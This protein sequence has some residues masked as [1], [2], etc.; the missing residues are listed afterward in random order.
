MSKH[1][2][3]KTGN[4]SP[5]IL[6]DTFSELL[7]ESYKKF[8]ISG[9]RLDKMILK[10]RYLCEGLPFLSG[11]LSDMLSVHN[12]ALDSGVFIIPDRAGYRSQRD[13]AMPRLFN[14]WWRRLYD[15]EGRILDYS[16]DGTFLLM[17]RALRQILAFLSK[18][19]TDISD[20]KIL[21]QEEDF[22][23]IDQSIKR[24]DYRPPKGSA[25]ESLMRN[26]SVVAKDV[27]STFVLDPVEGVHGPGAVFEGF[28]P[29]DKDIFYWR[30]IPMDLVDFWRSND[31]FD[32]PFVLAGTSPLLRVVSDVLLPI[33]FMTD[34]E[35][36]KFRIQCDRVYLLPGDVK[37]DEATPVTF[38]VKSAHRAVYVPKTWDKKRRIG[39]ELAVLQ[40]MQQGIKRQL[41]PH[42]Q[43]YFRKRFRFGKDDHLCGMFFN[44]NEENQFL[45]LYGSETGEACTIDSR[46]ASDMIGVWKVKE[47]LKDAHPALLRLLMITRSNDSLLFKSGNT[48]SVDPTPDYLTMRKF[49]G[50]GSA[51]TFP[52]ESLY[53]YCVSVAAISLHIYNDD[54]TKTDDKYCDDYNITRRLYRASRHVT[55]FGDDIIVH[56][57]GGDRATAMYEEVIKALELLG[58]VVNESKSFGHGIFRESCGTDAVLGSDVTPIKLRHILSEFPTEPDERK[59]VNTT[60]SIVSYAATANLL[61]E[62]G[63]KNTSNRMFSQI[64]ERFGV[65]PKIP[66]GFRNEAN[67]VV[68]W[69]D[70]DT[71]RCLRNAPDFKYR[72][73]SF[74]EWAIG[75]IY[76]LDYHLYTNSFLSSVRS[77]S[78]K[79]GYLAMVPKTKK[80]TLKQGNYPAFV[81]L[82]RRNAR[83]TKDCRYSGVDGL[84]R[85]MTMG[86]L[87]TITPGIPGIDIE[88]GEAT[89]AEKRYSSSLFYLAKRVNKKGKPVRDKKK[90]FSKPSSVIKIRHRFVELTRGEHTGCDLICR[91]CPAE[92]KLR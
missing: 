21:Q 8:N 45:A 81:G 29:I 50:M 89:S 2:P 64:R 28:S 24:G 87:S 17:E 31:D 35:Y 47:L 43:S 68:Q 18:V 77:S 69:V 25:E 80:D 92:S 52:V 48:K 57:L 90:D 59:L 78:Y 22:I 6:W 20:E 49:A 76:D 13:S 55:V 72:K 42:L 83:L 63:Y 33:F 44:S 88:R 86:K 15:C 7:D 36:V 62:K 58:G 38:L 51:T 41:Q 23:R 91:V 56:D 61:F 74:P 75:G 60:K 85:K 84:Q 40:A 16:L 9:L 73:L 12:S 32:L 82:Q 54:L 39:A 26:A 71:D 1:V 19:D 53:F 70:P 79:L 14:G 66:Y 46:A 11:I 34:D 27:L 4:E 67:G 10:R 3:D 5:D 37:F 65:V 30:S